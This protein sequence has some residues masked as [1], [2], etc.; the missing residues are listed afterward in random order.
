MAEK[1]TLRVNIAFVLLCI[2]WGT[3]YLGID[4]A[5]DYIPPFMLSALRHL[6]AGPFFL[7]YCFYN[8]E[9][10]PDKNTLWQLVW[11]GILLIVGG[12]A[13]VCWAE[14]VIP[15]GLTAV[16]C[17][18]SPMF[19]T[20]MSLFL[21]KEFKITYKIVLG[22]LLG[23]FGVVLI[24]LKDLS[25]SINQDLYFSLAA[26]MVAIFCWAL[27]SVLLKKNAIQTS[28]FMNIGWQMV[29]AGTINIV[30]SYFFEDNSNLLHTD[31]KG[32]L[33][34][35]YLIIAGSLIGY[36]SYLY[37]LNHYPPA[38][39]SIHSYM[40]TIIAVFVGWLI[41]GEKINEYIILGTLIV[42]AG[43]LIVNKE[44]TRLAKKTEQ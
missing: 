35:I 15:S 43:V 20:I 7:A 5:V 10:M 41:G 16:I 40:N 33:A 31:T 32:I 37:V 13:M 42:L 25:V 38:R 6:I 27:G 2:A 26:L 12:N 14:K 3:T 36:G 23:L 28:I 4:I 34:L 24:F 8:G 9:K 44:Y 18:L 1:N 11:M 19:I 39:V 29:F 17:S 22:L 30:I 21:F